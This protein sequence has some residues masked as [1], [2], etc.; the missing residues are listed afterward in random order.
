LSIKNKGKK[1]FF[2]KYFSTRVGGWSVYPFSKRCALGFRIGSKLT[3]LVGQTFLSAS[4]GQTGMSAP[5]QGCKKAGQSLHGLQA[6]RLAWA[7]P[8]LESGR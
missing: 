1:H 8:L 4:S 7:V 5:R 2:F 6:Y 3:D